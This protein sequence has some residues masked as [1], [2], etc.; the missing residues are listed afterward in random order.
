MLSFILLPLLLLLL[1]LSQSANVLVLSGAHGSRRLIT[2]NVATKLAEFGH[3]VTLFSLMD[4]VRQ[5][6]GDRKFTLQ[7]VEDV[8]G[9]A[10]K[11]RENVEEMLE[12]ILDLPSAEMVNNMVI[13]TEKA[14]QNVENYTEFAAAIYEGEQFAKLLEDVQFDLIA[15]EESAT[16]PAMKVLGTLKTPIIG[17][18]PIAATK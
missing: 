8:D 4:D 12:G 6:V 5:E 3:N 13:G 17:L 18:M 2:I 10:Q 15:V 1:S 7:S 16:I 9:R 11:L 14:W